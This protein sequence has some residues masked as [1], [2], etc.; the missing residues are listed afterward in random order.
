MMSEKRAQNSI[1]TTRHYPDLGSEANFQPIRGTTQILVVTR[2]ISMEFL[3]LFLKRFSG[4][5]L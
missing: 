1:L 3:R 4:V 5:A 2:V